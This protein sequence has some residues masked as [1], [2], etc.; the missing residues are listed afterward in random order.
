M[1]V[2]LRIFTMVL[3]GT[4]TL[5]ACV[6]DDLDN[7]T[8]TRSEPTTAVTPKPESTE[9]TTTSNAVDPAADEPSGRFPSQPDGVAW[10]TANWT[11]RDWPAEVDKAVI[12]EATDEVMAGGTTDRLR[13]VIIVHGGAIVYER[14]SPNPADDAEAVM[15]SYSIAKSVTSAMI[16][17]LVRDGTLDITSPAPVPEWQEPGDRRAHITVEHMLHMSAG[18]PWDDRP[19]PGSDVYEMTTSSDMAAYAAAQQPIADPGERFI[20]NTG[21]STLL[22][23]MISNLD[24]REIREMLDAELFDPIGMKPVRTMVDAEGTWAGGISADTSLRSFAKF[25]LLYL[26]GGWWDGK[27]LLDESWIEFSRNPSP[28]EPEYGAHWWLDMERPGVM[29]AL[30]FNGQVITVDPAHDLV[31]VQLATIG[32]PKMA[33]FTEV[34]LDAFAQATPPS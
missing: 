20:Y 15:P 9:A 8:T 26:R 16:G 18:M 21:T 34:I 33:S 6:A 3:A 1:L 19:E 27:R 24:G 2:R 29:Y 5:G 7:A 32:G 17:M 25:G 28:A 4:M 14:Y 23:R 31:I 11:T 10:P 13:G 22:A 12:D 30:G